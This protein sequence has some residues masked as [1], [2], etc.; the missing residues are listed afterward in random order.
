[1]K[2]SVGY[3]SNETGKPDDNNIATCSYHMTNSTSLPDGAH[4]CSRGTDGTKMNAVASVKRLSVSRRYERNII[5]R[6]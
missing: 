6:S 5:H 2:Q 3:L 4:D 1:M